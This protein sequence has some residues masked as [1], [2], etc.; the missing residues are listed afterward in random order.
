MKRLML[1][2]V[3]MLLGGHRSSAGVFAVNSPADISG[4][5]TINFD[6]YPDQAVAN[7]LLLGQG[8]TLT[9]DD[10]AAIYL[11]DW[12]AWGRT[13]TSPD[14]VLATVSDPD[15]HFPY[16][17]H[18]N[19]LFS[20]P[21]FALGAYFGNDQPQ[22]PNPPGDFSSARLSA[23]GLSGQLLGSVTV[24]ANHNT[25]VD[26]F[27]GIRSDVPFSRVRFENLSDLGSPSQLYAVVV[28]DLI[29]VPEP[30]TLS[31][32]AMGGLGALLRRHRK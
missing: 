19:A 9:R 27:I 12:T 14:N 5:T 25:S 17:T 30:A 13:T 24:A 1:M 11:V 22:S 29:F 20:F 16:A 26:Q 23:Y 4:A 6:G 15:A 31:L 21:V 7:T 32:L 10:G 28:D 2:A 8:V 3:L 18:L